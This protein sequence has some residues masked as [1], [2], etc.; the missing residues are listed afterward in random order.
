ML[1]ELAEHETY[2]ARSRAR[3]LRMLDGVRVHGVAEAFVAQLE[4][5][6]TK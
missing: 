3:V 5:A 2:M 4:R 6:W 1:R